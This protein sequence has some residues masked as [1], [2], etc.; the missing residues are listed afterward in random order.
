MLLGELPDRICGAVAR[1]RT[2][3]PIR[4][5]LD[6]PLIVASPEGMAH[7]SAP[8]LVPGFDDDEVVD[9][10]LVKG[11][12][13]HDACYASAEYEDPRVLVFGGECGLSCREGGERDSAAEHLKCE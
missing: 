9:A 2:L 1:L 5:Y 7:H 12:C 8:K 4:T 11:P 3:H 13:G 10:L 6:R